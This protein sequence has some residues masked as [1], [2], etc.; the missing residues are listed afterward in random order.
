[1]NMDVHAVKTS[2][3]GKHWFQSLTADFSRIE[4][5]AESVWVADG[6]IS[7]KTV[8]VIAVVPH[9]HNLYP[10]AQSGE[11]GLLEGWTLAKV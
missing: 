11:V 5:G 8:R 9:Q 6:Q 2:I 1:M 10:R 4:Q 7:G 3:R